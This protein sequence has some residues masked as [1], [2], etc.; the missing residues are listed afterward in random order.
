M[1]KYGR[2]FKN[3]KAKLSKYG[4]KKI[5][6]KA[7]II[8]IV[9]V[10]CL[11][12]G[13]VLF[14]DTL[15]KTGDGDTVVSAK[16]G[17]RV[18]PSETGETFKQASEGSKSE[19]EENLGAILSKIKGAGKVEV[20]I[21]FVSG[22]ESVPAVDV[23]TSENN[24]QEKDKEGGSRTIKQSDRENSIVYEENQGVKKPFIVK[25]LLPKV[26]G[27]VIVA[28]GAGEAEIK[29]N[30]AKATEALL[31]VAAHKIQVFQRNNN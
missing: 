5:I 6:E 21:T 28:D 11:I 17:D 16:V 8:A 2:I 9:G 14:E 25:E 3:L 12:A 24:T 23:N 20:M 1:G 4:S 7:V 13:S 22:S 31:D 10:I 19:M 27:V 15:K 30:L 29:S 18:N 26:K